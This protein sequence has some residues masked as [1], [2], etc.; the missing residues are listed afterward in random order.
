VPE[1]PEV[2]TVRAGLSPALT[3]A[4][5]TAIDV[6]DSRSFKRHIGGV[7]DFKATM[8][9]S[10]ILAVVRRGKFLWM[11]LELPTERG[12]DYKLA[13]VGHLGMS[14]QMLLRTP[15]FT[16]DSS[17]MPAQTKAKWSK[18]ASLTSASSAPWPLTS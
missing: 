5:V 10:K 13:M 18:C 9:G 16:E 3:N 1:L 7:E 14:G 2:E 11:P 15:G 8:I 12:G 17:S 4:V 6:L